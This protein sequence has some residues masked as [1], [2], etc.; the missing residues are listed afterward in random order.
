MVKDMK[1][2]FIILLICVIISGC[3][4]NVLI[5]EETGV[6]T[7][8][9]FTVS[10]EDTPLTKAYLEEDGSM[11]W[12]DLDCIGIFSDIQAPVP[13][14]R[15]DDGKFYG[16]EVT[17][18]QFYAYYPYSGFEYDE[19]NPTKLKWVYSLTGNY[20]SQWAIPMVSKSSNSKISWFNPLSNS[21]VRK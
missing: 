10:F 16:G 17:G 4:K 14:Y 2:E 21:C 19:E 6:K 3:V 20:N 5:Q 1:Y 13:F 12:D 8:D 11:K 15:G 7:F 18:T 9:C